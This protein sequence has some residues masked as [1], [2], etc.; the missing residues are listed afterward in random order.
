MLR[1]GEPAA[2]RQRLLHPDNSQIMSLAST[3]SELRLYVVEDEPWPST[4]SWSFEFSAP[5]EH[6]MTAGVYDRAMRDFRHDED[7]RP[8]ITIEGCDGDGR[9]EVKDIAFGPDDNLDRVWI[10]YEQSCSGGPVVGEVRVDMNAPAAPSP[11]IVRP[12]V[13]RWAETDLGRQN[14]ALAATVLASRDTQITGVSVGGESPAEFP[15][16]SD[17]CT[18]VSVPAGG[19]CQVF[20]RFS[21]GAAGTRT[22]VLTVTEANGTGHTVA[23]EGFSWGPTTQAVMGGEADSPYTRTYTPADSDFSA[24]IEGAALTFDVDGPEN[25]AGGNFGVHGL[26]LPGVGNSFAPGRYVDPGPRDDPSQPHFEVYSRG[27]GGC[28]ETRGEFTVTDIGF[29]RDG[30]LRNVGID[31]TEYCGD[32]SIPLTGTLDFRKADPTP[33]PPWI[34]GAWAGIPM[35]PG[36]YEAGPPWITEPVP[37]PS[38]PPAPQ[39][40]PD[41]PA[42]TRPARPC[43]SRVFS[44]AATKLGTRRADRIRGHR[45][46]DDLIFARGGRDRVSAL[47]GRD[48]VDG[49]RGGDRLY[50]GPGNDVVFGGPGR[51]LIDCGRGRHDIARVTSGDRVRNCEKRTR[52][53]TPA[54]PAAWP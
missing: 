14:G 36:Q 16:T 13:L 40:G 19:T 38:D 54:T 4:D 30:A 5:L 51:D 3:R 27:G 50:G 10:V 26:F 49:G 2:E 7:G 44:R 15:V 20:M 18:G 24:L 28:P 52:R 21:P 53:R 1:E 48:C 41:V 25:P 33:P 12:S 17:G 46:R 23:L 43:S 39:S 6:E 11:V 35:S 32:N 45:T 37:G 9:F 29:H 31:F 34:T 42:P 8:G 47:G 22:A